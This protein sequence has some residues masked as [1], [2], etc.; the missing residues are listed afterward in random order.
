MAG[1]YDKL[2]DILRD[3]L[4]GDE[5]PFETWEPH[6]GKRREAGNARE[7]TPPPI[8]NPRP[9]RVAVPPELVEDFRVLGLMPGVTPGECKSAWKRLLKR[10]H[11]DKNGRTREEQEDSTRISARINASYRRI[12]T[13]YETGKIPNS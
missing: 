13:W 8:R 9:E 1:F 6:A 12:T 2:G 10:Y 3:R 7:R 5:D 11:P 4:D